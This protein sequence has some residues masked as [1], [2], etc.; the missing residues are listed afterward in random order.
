MHTRSCCHRETDGVEEKKIPGKSVD[1]YQTPVCVFQ[2]SADIAKIVKGFLTQHWDMLWARLSHLWALHCPK[3]AGRVSLRSHRSI[4]STSTVVCFSF[5]FFS[6]LKSNKDLTVIKNKQRNKWSCCGLNYISIHGSWG[7]DSNIRRERLSCQPP[8]LPAGT[9][10]ALLGEGLRLLPTLRAH[11]PAEAK[12]GNTGHW[13]GHSK[14][15]NKN[16]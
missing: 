10:P 7:T 6:T 1:V 15:K 13:Y 3:L 14:I 8:A 5:F 9:P 12:G 2:S 16:K 4:A 11:T